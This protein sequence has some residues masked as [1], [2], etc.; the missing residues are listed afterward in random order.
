MDTKDLKVQVELLRSA[1]IE[2]LHRQLSQGRLE[3]NEL[4]GIYE[5]ERWFVQNRATLDASVA[6]RFEQLLRSTV[7]GLEDLANF[8]RKAL[9]LPEDL[10]PSNEQFQERI[11]LL[12]DNFL[13]DA[14]G[15]MNAAEKEANAVVNNFITIKDIVGPVNVLSRLD[16]VVQTV[17]NSPALN[18]QQQSDLATLFRD[19][20]EC[21]ANA[22]AD[23]QGDA[24]FVAEQAEAVAKELKR[25]TVRRSALTIKASGLVDAANVLKAIVPTALEI[26]KS[27]AVFVSGA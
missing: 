6:T 13:K 1:V 14:S 11:E 25:A 19:L 4:K 16:G 2:D 12:W 23:K 9:A 18:P 17:T 10:R 5:A 21:L 20:K 22:P 15:V 3:L 24:E 27:I 26:A 8:A 7:R